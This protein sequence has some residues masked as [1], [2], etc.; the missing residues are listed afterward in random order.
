MLLLVHCQLVVFQT[1]RMVATVLLLLAGAIVAW[2]LM[3]I[4]LWLLCWMM[5]I[6]IVKMLWWSIF[7]DYYRSVQK[8]KPKCNAGWFK[9]LASCRCT[10]WRFL[11]CILIWS[12]PSTSK[13]NHSPTLSF[14][15]PKFFSIASW[16]FRI[17]LWI[18]SNNFGA[19][20][21]LQFPQSPP[22]H[23]SLIFFPLFNWKYYHWC[24]C[25]RWIRR[26]KLL[27]NIWGL[28]NTS[29]L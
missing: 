17:S 11:T 25:F 18:P 7:P 23:L 8:D 22:K 12:I 29:F 20:W 9:Q 13:P 14:K 5:W 19:L 21:S 2:I 28:T 10:F 6:V 16:S 15:S 4:Q 3:E 27:V 24:P 26:H 1:S